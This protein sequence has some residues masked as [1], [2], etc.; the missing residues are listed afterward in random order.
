MWAGTVV[1]PDLATVGG[2]AF[3]DLEV[4]VRGGELQ[5]PV[6]RLQQHV[7]QDGN[8]VP[9]LHDALNMGERLEES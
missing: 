1:A 3:D 5:L 6:T 8:G 4:E 7:G 9:A 2:H